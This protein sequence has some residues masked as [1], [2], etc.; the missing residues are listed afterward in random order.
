MFC[1][2]VN[3]HTSSAQGDT[4]PLSPIAASS[5]SY[6]TSKQQPINNNMSSPTNEDGASVSKC[7]FFSFH[8]LL[9][10]KNM[11]DFLIYITL[12]AHKQWKAKSTPKQICLNSPL[13]LQCL[14]TQTL[15]LSSLTLLFAPCPRQICT[16]IWMDLFVCRPS[17]I[18]HN[19][20]MS[21]L[22]SF[23]CSM[24]LCLSV[25]SVLTT[26]NTRD[27]IG[28]LQTVASLHSGRIETAGLQ[29]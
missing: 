17:S 26:R 18:W 12:F 15:L 24:S 27:L 10:T 14:P 29:G 23:L 28:P 21:R 11:P 5:S 25:F 13:Q 7:L 16:C 4:D 22:A 2:S 1:L 9:W 3:T 19:N 8:R 20:I 6:S